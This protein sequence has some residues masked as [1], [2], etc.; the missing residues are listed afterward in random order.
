MCHMSKARLHL[1]RFGRTWPGSAVHSHARLHQGRPQLAKAGRSW[2]GLGS[3]APTGAPAPTIWHVLGPRHQQSHKHTLD[4]WDTPV[5][6]QF[7]QKAKVGSTCI[8]GPTLNHHNCHSEAILGVPE[9]RRCI[10]RHG[11][12]PAAPIHV[13]FGRNWPKEPT[14]NRLRS[15]DQGRPRREAV[16]H[17]VGRTSWSSRTWHIGLT[18]ST[19]PPCL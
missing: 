11:G 5:N 12:G 6:G 19:N 4:G 3:A 1:A 16:D 18:R 9:R 13:C 8:D 2:P 7:D 17:R 15:S 14:Y 10:T